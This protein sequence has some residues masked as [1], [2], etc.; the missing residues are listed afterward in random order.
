[1]KNLVSLSKKYLLIL[2]GIISVALGVLGIFL[3]LLPTT[4]FLLFAAFCFVKS[5]KKFYYWLIN[6]RILGIYIKNYIHHRAITQKSRIISISLL[7]IT[8]LS[9]A[10]FFVNVV[11]VKV[12]L[13]C[14]ALAVSYHLISLKTLRREQVTNYKE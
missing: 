11:W 13:I 1:V 4:P 5:S 12:L 8:I 7:W 3:P 10:I 14:I 6:H 2:V 9:S